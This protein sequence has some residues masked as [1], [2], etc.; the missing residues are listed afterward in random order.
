MIIVSVIIIGFGGLVGVEVFIVLIGLVIGLNLGSM[1][2]MEY[3]I[4]ML[5]VG[6]GVV[7]VIGGIFKVFIVG[8]VFM[9]E[10]LMIDFIMLFLLLLLILVVMV[11]IVL[12]IMIG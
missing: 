2:K 12:Y 9:L 6:C 8:L 1:F 11:V 4:L 5:L 7:G 10:V 3:C